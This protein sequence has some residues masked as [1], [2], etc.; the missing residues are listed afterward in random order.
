MP[1]VGQHNFDTSLK[2][3][4]DKVQ[5]LFQLSDAQLRKLVLSS[6]HFLGLSY[7]NVESKVVKLRNRLG[8]DDAQLTRLVLGLP[9][10]L[11]YNYETNVGPTLDFFQQE[12]GMS[13]A[14]LRDFVLW[15]SARLCYSLETRYK[16]RA[17]LC[18]A[19]G[20]PMIVVFDNIWK[21]D[22][23]FERVLSQYQKVDETRDGFSISS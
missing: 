2:P 4:L 16:P 13:D 18:R 15:N 9:S 6:P 10:L 11:T 14:Q 20:A 1:Q 7:D 23:N 21:S 22:T 5:R 12:L 3:Y 17:E 8:L 19:V